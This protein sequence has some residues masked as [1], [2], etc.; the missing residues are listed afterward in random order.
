M[1]TRSPALITAAVLVTVLGWSS[2]FIGS[3][4]GAEV[5]S[6]GAMGLGRMLVATA[7]LG[8]LAAVMH[9]RQGPGRGRFLPPQR[10]WGWI[11]LWGFC[12]FTLYN[13]GMNS[14]SQS[15][16]AGT[17]ALIVYLAPLLVL[18]VAGLRLGE[19]FPPRLIAG[20][21]ISFAGVG[22]IAAAGNTHGVT[23][24]GLLFSL[25]AAVTY[26]AS[27]IIQKPLL[28][29]VNSFTM[30]F[31]GAA[32]GAVGLLPFAGDLVR[33]I[34]QHPAETLGWIF[35]L[36]IVPTAISFTTWAYALSA[37]PAGQASAFTY[38]VPALTVVMGWL[39]L[40]EVP[41]ALV[42]LGGAL[43]LGG[44]FFGR[45]APWGRGAEA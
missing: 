2:A 31:L 8:I 32:V 39:F 40:G 1:P 18:I 6:P 41:S 35:F 25:L 17:V 43:C 38:L 13:L 10:Y 33:Q 7:A 28:G 27:V 3:R 9:H 36:G 4:G 21:V 44:V 14:A 20:A 11:A 15:M 26:A 30:T 12:W 19:G 5:L 24:S 42:L 29:R 23:A 45:Y 16:D 34:P 37:I 22:I